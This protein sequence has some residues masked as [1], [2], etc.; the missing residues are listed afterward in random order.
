[1]TTSDSTAHASAVRELSDGRHEALRHLATLR[2]QQGPGFDGRTMPVVETP[3]PITHANAAVA[4]YLAQIR[5]YREKTDKWSTDLG[6]V[7][8]EP[9]FVEETAGRRSGGGNVKTLVGQAAYQ[10][11]SLSDVLTVAN[12]KVTYRSPATG[13]EQRLILFQAAELQE[14]FRI[15]DDCLSELNMLA[16]VSG[17]GGASADYSDLWPGNGGDDE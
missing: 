1:M 17:E 9:Q 3:Q 2:A 10:I 13:D 6:V 12:R 8:L 5:P 14:I 16:Q 4:N 15:A 11:S 7:E